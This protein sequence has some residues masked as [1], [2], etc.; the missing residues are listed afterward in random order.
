MDSPPPLIT[1]TFADRFGAIKLR[2]FLLFWTLFFIGIV[3]VSL[4][5][6]KSLYAIV[7]AETS[8]YSISFV[9]DQ[10]QYT[11]Q[12]TIPASW[13]NLPQI[14]KR[15]QAAIVSS[16]D[17]TFYLHPGYDLEQLQKA[18]DETFVKKKKM[19]GASTITQQLVKNLFLSKGKTFGR[20]AQELIM[21]S[22]IEKYADKKKILESY[23]NIIEYG[24]GLYGIQAASKFYFNKLPSQ[25]NAREAAFLAML[26]PSPV[27]YARSFNAK[28]LTPFA[29][30]MV[31]SILLKMR[32][33]GHISEE[34]YNQQRHMTFAWEKPPKESSAET[35]EEL[36]VADIISSEDL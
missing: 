20:K 14:S 33:G 19:R 4:P 32:Q 35:S 9:N 8:Y 28:S 15:I 31:E 2:L 29:Q 6:I 3:A 27:R 1:P 11:R 17:G 36:S 12:D 5:T 7:H 24:K 22:M 13:V 21:A 18:I 16:E 34:E 10:V 23:L 30:R 26:L 25:I